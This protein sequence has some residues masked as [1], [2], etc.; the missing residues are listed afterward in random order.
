MF[1]PWGQHASLDWLQTALKL[2]AVVVVIAAAA[3]PGERDVVRL[4]ALSGA[5]LIAVQLP[6][7]HWFYFY[8]IWFAPFALVAF[9]AGHGAPSRLRSDELVEPRDAVPVRDRDVA[10]VG[11]RPAHPEPVADVG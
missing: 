4:A 2:A 11:L 9:L 7:T 5:T 1:S 3:W 10:V 8:V 6:A